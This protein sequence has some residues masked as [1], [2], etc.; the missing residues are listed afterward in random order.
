MKQKLGSLA[1]HRHMADPKGLPLLG[2]QRMFTIAIFGI[3]DYKP[4]P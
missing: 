4:I 2:F 1:I 3:T